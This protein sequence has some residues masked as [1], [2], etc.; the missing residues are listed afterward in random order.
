M[1]TPPLRVLSCLRPHRGTSIS[2]AGPC[3]GA[4][5]CGKP[6]ERGKL[7]LVLGDVLTNS[8]ENCRCCCPELLSSWF[9]RAFPNFVRT[10]AAARPSDLRRLAGRSQARPVDVAAT[11]PTRPKSKRHTRLA[12]PKRRQRLRQHGNPPR[13]QGAPT[14]ERNGIL[15]KPMSCKELCSRVRR[16]ATT[17]T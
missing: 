4:A 6:E 15:S 13:S 1:A 12:P 2:H 8:L 17:N 3:F 9:A 10:L 5:S 16:I 7:E 11:L 14:A